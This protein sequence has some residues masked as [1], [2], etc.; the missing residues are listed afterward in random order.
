S[1]PGEYFLIPVPTLLIDVPNGNYKV[2][3]TLDDADHPSNTIVKEGLGHLKI[4]QVKTELGKFVKRCFSVHVSDGQL[5]LAFGGLN[6]RVKHVEVERL[7][8]S[9]NNYLSDI[10]TVTE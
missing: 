4:N 2:T 3:L 10:N 6:P 7:Q 9:A 8:I 5:K 1:W